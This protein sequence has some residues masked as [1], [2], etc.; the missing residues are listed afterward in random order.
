MRSSAVIDMVVMYIHAVV[1][2]RECKRTVGVSTT[3]LVGRLAVAC[4]HL[5]LFAFPVLMSFVY[6]EFLLSLLRL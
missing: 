1:L 5:L 6:F 4:A 3:D 2:C